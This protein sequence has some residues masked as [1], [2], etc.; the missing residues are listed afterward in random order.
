MGRST[1]QQL[2]QRAKSM[3]EYNNSGIASDVVW[4]DHFNEALTSMVD[5]LAIQE[6]YS[7]TCDPAVS[8]YNLPD[9]YYKLISIT[10]QSDI[11][12]STFKDG[13]FTLD[14]FRNINPGYTIQNKGPN[15]ALELKSYQPD[16][17][18]VQYIR[19]PAVLELANINTQKPEVPTVGENALCL[20]AIVHSLENNN[21][22]GQAQEFE[23]KYLNE[24]QKIDKANFKAKGD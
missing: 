24:L 17:L 22:L 18:T 11:E 13:G 6:S 4:I 15:Y 16:S 20:K 7:I 23:R 2:I 14:G 8:V 19:Y 9:D 1:V 10:D 12:L 5:E 21:Q 3:N